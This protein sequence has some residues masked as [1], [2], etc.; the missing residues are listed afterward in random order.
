MSK[1][2]E[3]VF[4]QNGNPTGLFQFYCPGCKFHHQINTNP[5]HGPVWTFNGDLASP[6]AS[7]SLLV[8]YPTS[9]GDR[10]CH[11]FVRN[12]MIEFLND[13]THDLAGKTVEIP[14]ID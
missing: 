12:G 5:E 1:K 8:T 2:I 13:C 14:N 9:K 6:T 4:N 7:P 11:S 3:E 10:K